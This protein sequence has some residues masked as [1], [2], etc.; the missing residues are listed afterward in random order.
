MAHPP[1]RS[2]PSFQPRIAKF[3][4]GRWRLLWVGRVREST[5]ANNLVGYEIQAHLCA[6]GRSSVPP[7]T[8]W[9]S[10]TQLTYLRPQSLWIDGV[11]SDHPPGEEL[12]FVVRAQDATLHAPWLPGTRDND[13]LKH[14]D[15]YFHKVR[16]L[17]PCWVF[18]T[19]DN[20]QLV[21]PAWEVL[22]AW[23]LFDSG[24]MPAVLAGAVRHV[25]S[26][27]R[28]HQPW[29][30]GTGP[31]EHDG[32]WQYVRPHW[33]SEAQALRMAR[34]VFDDY[35]YAQAYDIFRQLMLAKQR[36]GSARDAILPLPAVKPPY[37]DD[38]V[39]TV[40]CTPISPS[41]SGHKR[42][43]VLSLQSVRAPDTL[44]RVHMQ[45]ER[46][47]GENQGDPNL[48]VY[49]R[50]GKA[51]IDPHSSTNLSLVGAAP[52]EAVQSA[53]IEG[54]DF[55]DDIIDCVEVVPSPKIEQVSRFVHAPTDPVLIAGGATDLAARPRGQH[56]R[57]DT[58]GA[59]PPLAPD[60]LLQQTL[61]AFA[62]VS[63]QAGAELGWQGSFVTREGGRTFPVR[64]RRTGQ[65]RHFAI[66]QVTS[67]TLTGYALEAQRFSG[68]EFSLCVCRSVSHLPMNARLFESWLE[69]FPAPRGSP[70][71]GSGIL[72]PV[73]E[74]DPTRVPH[75][76]RE[77]SPAEVT[78]RLARRLT[79]R[80]RAF[81]HK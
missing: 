21:V 53:R 36:A 46:D 63:A 75:Q 42:Y 56:A 1:K 7:E 66:L 19:Q 78:R 27:R 61:D 74:V 39:W 15:Y 32:Q 59:Y 9:I 79:L 50:K 26:L 34:L 18:A 71:W 31:R 28:Q 70:W 40:R 51:P 64:S 65:I 10:L 11:F 35:A 69:Q 43:L 6:A 44:G 80:L 33:M 45:G 37:Q 8:R 29:L 76:Q 13:L 30:A 2:G 52:D 24:V 16:D 22:R 62:L 4:K 58:E 60:D 48:P 73:V 38:S 12:S 47:P 49:Q 41:A 20:V 17:A 68:E 25:A 72:P 81:L 54:F 23:Y 57:I 14:G 55:Y 5:D 77:H 67:G 3:P